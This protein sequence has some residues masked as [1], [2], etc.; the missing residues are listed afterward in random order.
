[1]CRYFAF[2]DPKKAALALTRKR[3]WVC[4]SP[5]LLKYNFDGGKRVVR[6][7]RLGRKV[8][9]ESQPPKL[10]VLLSGCNTPKIL[11][12][13]YF[14]GHPMSRYGTLFSRV[15]AVQKR[16]R[17]DALVLRNS[18]VR[19]EHCPC[20]EVF[21]FT[22]IFWVRERLRTLQINFSLQNILPYSKELGHGNTQST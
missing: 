19:V 9:G 15:A 5:I 13:A 16:D 18:I 2:A 8:L 22:R 7:T 21:R 10:P 6:E 4:T 12:L 17:P 3:F 20:N 14:S 1:M 11:R